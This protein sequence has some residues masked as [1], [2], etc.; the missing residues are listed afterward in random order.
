MYSVLEQPVRYSEYSVEE[1][2]QRRIRTALNKCLRSFMFEVI[3]LTAQKDKY[4]RKLF[5]QVCTE[6]GSLCCDT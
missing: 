1:F 4:Y 3:F 2:V 6:A 5:L